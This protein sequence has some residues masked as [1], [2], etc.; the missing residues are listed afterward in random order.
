MTETDVSKHSTKGKS[1]LICVGGKL[2]E[3]SSEPNTPMIDVKKLPKIDA[4]CLQLAG[5]SRF[6][7]ATTEI[8]SVAQHSCFVASLVTSKHP[9]LELPAL[10]HDLPEIVYG[11]IVTGIKNSVGMVLTRFMEQIDVLVMNHYLGRFGFKYP[12][13]EADAAIIK[14]AD[15][16][17]LA[18]EAQALLPVGV[19]PSD[20]PDKWPQVELPQIDSPFICQP[21]DVACKH[22]LDRIKAAILK[23]PLK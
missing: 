15:I 11:D 16:F 8:Y 6:N 13:P 21:R 19:R 2:Q 14:E 4:A 23:L 5:I 1:R 10:L 18:C 3:I 20:V 9:R 12:L 22:M 17:A 7:G